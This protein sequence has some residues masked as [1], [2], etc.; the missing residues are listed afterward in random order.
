IF[1]D[2]AAGTARRGAA[3]AGVEDTLLAIESVTGGA[4]ND[5][6]SGSG[7]ANVLNGGA[8]NDTLAGFGG[9]DTLIG[10][11]GNDVLAGGAGNDTI[12]AGAGDDSITWAVGDG[13]DVVSGG[14][15]TDKFVITGSAANETFWIETVA[16]YLLRT[17]TA[18]GS[19][20]GATEIVV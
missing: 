10:G 9:A 18:P 7:T 20:Q 16:D 8:G 1:V 2:L 15:G 6:I 11:E 14:E 5:T 3:D 12:D 17:G 19:L 4:G 13:R